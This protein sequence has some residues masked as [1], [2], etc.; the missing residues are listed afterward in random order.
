[1]PQLASVLTDRDLPLAELRAML[2]DGELV[3]VDE[4]FAPID[5]PP[6]PAQRAASVA[7]YCQQR[8]IAEQ[9]TAAWIW[10]AIGEAPQR[11]ELCVSIGARARTN[12]PGRLTVREVVISED[13]IATLGVVRVTRPLRTVVDL[14]RF[15]E[16]LDP[17][18][19]V[20]LMKAAGLTVEACVDELHRRHNLPGK[21]LAL[22]RLASLSS[23]PELTR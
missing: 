15:Q 17:A 9:R 4:A 5:Q 20:S 19:V 21:K 14:T 6:S 2:L 16:R 10:G 1:M 22:K 11:H 8:L 7:M 18:L 13:E 3:A 12:H 23:Y